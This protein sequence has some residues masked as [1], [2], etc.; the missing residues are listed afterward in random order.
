MVYAPPTARNA[1]LNFHAERLIISDNAARNAPHR[2]TGARLL[3]IWAVASG[4]GFLAGFRAFSAR[5]CAHKRAGPNRSTAICPR[6][7][8][9]TVLRPFTGA[10]ERASSA[11]P[12]EKRRNPSGG[13]RLR[14]P[15]ARGFTFHPGGKCRNR[16]HVASRS[17]RRRH[18]LTAGSFTNNALPSNER[19]EKKVSPILDGALFSIVIV[20]TRQRHE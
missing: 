19:N 5:L 1:R 3:T 8:V 17:E 20:A 11:P 18:A 14:P 9:L 12:R 13:R 7:R 4:D 15:E 16:K 2:I 10:L 6:N